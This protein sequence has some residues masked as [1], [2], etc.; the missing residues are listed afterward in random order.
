MARDGRSSHAIITD[1]ESRRMYITVS[2]PRGCRLEICSVNGYHASLCPHAQFDSGPRLPTIEAR[3]T[4]LNAG[5]IT[6]RRQRMVR[7]VREEVRMK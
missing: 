7:C 4:G 2:A 1:D 5:Y 3:L 6:A